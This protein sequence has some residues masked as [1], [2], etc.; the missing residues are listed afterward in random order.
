MI[1]TPTPGFTNPNHISDAAL[2]LFGWINA[3]PALL[4]LVIL[5][6]LD[7]MTGIFASIIAANLSSSASWKGM[8][9][10]VIMIILI[11]LASVLEPFAQGI[12]LSKLV[13]TFYIVT[14]ALSIVENAARCG[15]P[16][17]SALVESLAKLREGQ[18]KVPALV[19]A[20]AILAPVVPA[21]VRV[22]NKRPIAVTQTDGSP[23]PQDK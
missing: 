3:S 9:K 5:M 10:K 14:E 16:L 13:A 4:A 17:P 2:A 19:Q 1:P 18:A 15:V 22:V 20:A 12:P 6:L 23:D 8:S 7:I 21:E 11:G